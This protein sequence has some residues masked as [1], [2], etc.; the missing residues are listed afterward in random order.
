M[1]FINYH[2]PD[3]NNEEIQ[4]VIEVM[5]SGWLTT[6]EVCKK[7]EAEF[8][9]FLSEENLYCLSVNSATAGLHLALEAIGI[10]FGDEVITTTHTFTA[11]AEVARY[12]G[13]EVA[14][15]DIDPETY[16]IDI[17][18]IEEKITSR[19]KCI[20]AVHFGGLSCNLNDLEKLGEKYSIPIIE[21]AAHALPTSFNEKLIGTFNTKA[22]VFS[23]YANKTM[24]TG[25]GGMLVT[26]DEKL[27]KRAQLMR[28]HGIDR[29]PFDRFKQRKK[30]N[31]YNIIEAG[32]KYNMT[33]IAAAI[34]VEQL[35]KINM[36]S[37]RREQ[38]AKY[39]DDSLNS[40]PIKLPPRSNNDKDLH[41]WHIYNIVLD[42]QYKLLDRNTLIHKLSEL[43][44]GTSIH[45]L[46]LHMQPYWCKRYKLNQGMF[47]IST[48]VYSNCLSLPIYNL[49]TDSEVE[50]IS[51]TLKSILVN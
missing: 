51:S 14:F 22:T 41:A 27:Y 29:D 5:R 8:K 6:G 25:E 44:I 43:N 50:Y 24:T 19:T 34:G 35:K 4:S 46:P 16:C 47:P 20:I 13:A 26:H 36:M 31:T 33:D 45:Y 18:K 17:N 3:L 7:F 23:F 38:I 12:L 40:L 37:E 2:K 15:V 10:G 11:T 42:D 49:L 21:D 28:L 1:A 32:F 30:T 48:A 39:Y 9:T